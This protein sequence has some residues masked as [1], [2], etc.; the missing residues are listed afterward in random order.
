MTHR[1]SLRS[2]LFT[3]Y[4]DMSALQ[5]NKPPLGSPSGRDLNDPLFRRARNIL[6]DGMDH[7]GDRQSREGQRLLLASELGIA[8][9]SRFAGIRCFDGMHDE[10]SIIRRRRKSATSG[11]VS[12]NA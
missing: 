12:A 10:L 9:T 1:V 7:A 3:A 2:R 4:L 6:H 8:A 5:T 11:T